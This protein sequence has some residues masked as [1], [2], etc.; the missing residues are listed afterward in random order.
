MAK[1]KVGPCCDICLPVRVNHSAV[2]RGDIPASLRSKLVARAVINGYLAV[3]PVF[4]IQ[5]Q[6]LDLRNARLDTFLKVFALP[7]VLSQRQS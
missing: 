1:V 4:S 7:V 2:S 6:Y 3:L 5:S